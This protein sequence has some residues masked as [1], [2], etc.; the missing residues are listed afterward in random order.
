MRKLRALW[1][2]MYG[3]FRAPIVDDEF[4]DELDSHIA[5]H[6]EEGVRAGLSPVEARRRALIR[7]GGA[8]QVRQAYREQRSIP[9]LEKPLQDVRFGMRMMTRKPA[10]TAVAVLTLAIGIGASTAIFSA[11]KPILIDPL[12]YPHAGRIMMLWEMRKDSAPMD[13]T[14]G[15]F[16]GFEE[17]SRS[18]DAM[19]VMKPWQPAMTETSQFDRPE[20]LQAQR[21]SANYFRT[22][23]VAPLLG[24]DFEQADDRFQGPNVAILSDRLWRRH[25]AADAAIVGKQVRLDDSLYTV[26]GVMPAEFENVL[27]PTAEVWAPLQYDP[28]LPADGREWGHHLRMVGRLKAG[29]SSSQARDEL[30]GILHTLAQSFARGYNSS[31]GAPDAMAVNPLER[32]LTQGVRPALLAILGAVILLLLIACV[33]VA[34]LLLARGGQ[35]SSE[36]AMR[37]ALGADHGRPVGQLLTES[38]MLA[39]LGGALGLAVALAGVRALVALSPQGLPRASAIH[40]DGGVFLFAFCITALIAMVACMVQT[41]QASRCGLNNSMRQTSRHIAGGRQWTR[42]TLVVTEVSLAVVLLVS[43]GLLLRSMQRLFA[44]APGFDASHLLTMQVEEY[45][46][47]F[48]SDAARV[49]F[50]AQA[51][52]TV[53]RIPGVVSAGLTAQLP[54]SGDYDVYG[55]EVESEHNLL[56]GAA[57]RYAVTPG[58]IETMRIPLRRGRLLNEA[59]VAGA[60]VAVLINESFARRRFGGKDPIGQHVHA[61]PDMGHADRPWATIVGV[62]GNVKQA[63]LAI[64]DEDAFYISTAQW[65]WTDEVQSVVVRTRGDALTFAPAVRDAIW[66][67]DRD[68]PIERIASVENLLAASARERR[69]VLILFEAFGLAALTLAA[70]GIY[71]VVAGSVNERTREISVRAALGATRGD[72]LV[73]VMRQGMAMSAVGLAIGL[74]GALAAGRALTSLLFSVTWLDGVTYFGAA[75]LLLGVSVIACLIPARRAASIDPAQALRAE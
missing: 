37:A 30:S 42:R 23:G 69:F 41:W 21:V 70:I 40:V 38:L 18:F 26:I 24:R 54:L 3:S 49:R 1:K 71:G 2:R 34:H 57:L 32:D 64:G 51:L 60:P 50:Y 11:V 39:A 53:R 43:A 19:A 6:T 48:L 17:R 56:G 27:A 62:V 74:C 58:Y 20:R 7:L 35:R 52:D 9:W 12:P 46:H 36:F 68:L 44:V 14:F 47:R 67:V 13:V 63:S 25:F 8:E 15:T 22:F 55:V 59:D 73:L 72:I 61:G 29:V 66:S 65:A 4:A 45:G 28:S 10:F 31:G 75:A 16:H 5:L 33:N